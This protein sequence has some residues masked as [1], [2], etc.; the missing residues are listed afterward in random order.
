M[1]LPRMTIRRWVIIVMISGLQL[2]LIKA[3]AYSLAP[4]PELFDWVLSTAYVC[5]LESL[6]GVV[7]LWF[8]KSGLWSLLTYNGPLRQS[9]QF[10]GRKRGFVHGDRA[11]SPSR[12]QKSRADRTVLP[13]GPSRMR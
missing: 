2:G 8:R 4:Q 13:V 3:G 10:T 6:L 7:I 5:G 1:S 11:T 12:S 9:R